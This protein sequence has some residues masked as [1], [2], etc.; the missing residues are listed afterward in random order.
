MH[1][2]AICRI[3][4]TSSMKSFLKFVE[5]NLYFVGTIMIFAKGYETLES[6]GYSENSE[7]IAA[8]VAALFPLIVYF[9]I[10]KQGFLSSALFGDDTEP[11]DQDGEGVRVM[12][13]GK[14]SL[15]KLE[16]FS[17]VTIYA[18][19]QKAS[20]YEETD[21]SDITFVEKQSSHTGTSPQS[22]DPWQNT[23]Q[24][25]KGI[26]RVFVENNSSKVIVKESLCVRV[27]IAKG[28]V[29][30]VEEAFHNQ[31]SIS[32]G[33][34]GVV[35]VYFENLDRSG[36]RSI[37]NQTDFRIRHQDIAS[38]PNGISLDKYHHVSFI[39]ISIGKKSFKLNQNVHF[40]LSVGGSL[41][42]YQLVPMDGDFWGFTPS[43]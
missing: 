35:D 19:L 16:P 34:I 20:Q 11:E 1:I 28:R 13:P 8:A 29:A 32:P 43:D 3:G 12:R 30:S 22:E 14:F 40:L 36:L 15:K 9:S 31:L 6:M 42:F 41:G 24:D 18:K 33:M 17:G 39:D 27:Q 38:D 25:F 10:R 5:I 23:M 7:I 4:Q 2:M 26:V 37:I 21:A